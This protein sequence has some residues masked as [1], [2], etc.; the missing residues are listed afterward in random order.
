MAMDILNHTKK[1]GLNGI[2]HKY[3]HVS[4]DIQ[5]ALEDN[6]K[7]LAKL[8][9]A[10]EEVLSEGEEKMKDIAV[11]VQRSVKKNPWVYIGAASAGALLLGFILGKKK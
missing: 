11:D 3:E 10:T 9:K 6:K 5:A 7:A 8:K 4:H 1:N 2:M